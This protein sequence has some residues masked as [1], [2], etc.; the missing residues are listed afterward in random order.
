LLCVGLFALFFACGKAEVEEAIAEETIVTIEVTATET[1]TEATTTE[2]PTTT[3][4]PTTTQK[5]TAAQPKEVKLATVE[6]AIVL[7]Q[8]G[9]HHAGPRARRAVH[10]RL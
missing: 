10:A 5:S 1:T 9:V 7:C 2:P 3:R 4:K 6:E 8:A